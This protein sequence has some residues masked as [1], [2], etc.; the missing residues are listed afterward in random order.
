MNLFKKFDKVL[1]LGYNCDVKNLIYTNGV[2]QETNFFDD[3]GTSMWSICDLLKNDFSGLSE[4]E[5]Y[6][7]MNIRERHR[8]L[9]NKKYYIRFQHESYLFNEHSNNNKHNNNLFDMFKTLERRADRFKEH[10]TKYNKILFIRLEEC[11]KGRIM[12]PEYKEKNNKEEYEYVLEFSRII[13]KKYKNLNYFI[14]YIS[15]KK[16]K[17]Y[18]E[19]N[20]VI[21]LCNRECEEKLIDVFK[22]NIDLL[23]NI[24]LVD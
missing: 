12:Y 8:I 13:K 16:Y 10:L 7:Q 24:L 17:E 21:T 9:V 6:G 3:K 4:I 14:I 22:N 1:S 19:E 2:N 11:N 15:T 20:K 23:N 18:D 5:N